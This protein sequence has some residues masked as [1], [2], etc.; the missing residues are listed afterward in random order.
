MTKTS[1]T[2]A[3][4]SFAADILE[5]E[6]R[7]DYTGVRAQAVQNFIETVFSWGS[8]GTKLYRLPSGRKVKDIR[9]A[10]TEWANS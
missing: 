2:Y 10:I 9:R 1:M 7:G 5:L 8:A 4:K 6:R 3:A